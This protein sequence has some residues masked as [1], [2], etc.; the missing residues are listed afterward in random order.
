MKRLWQ[1]ST[2]LVNKKEKRRGGG[3][4]GENSSNKSYLKENRDF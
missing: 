2:F 4:E 1:Y 3:G